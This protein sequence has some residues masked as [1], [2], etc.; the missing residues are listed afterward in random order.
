M[1]IIESYE[2]KNIDEI[3]DIN[4]EVYGD[5]SNLKSLDNRSI[6][7]SNMFL[8]LAEEHEKYRCFFEEGVDANGFR[9][10]HKEMKKNLGIGVVTVLQM[11]RKIKKYSNKK[12]KKLHFMKNYWKWN[13][14]SIYEYIKSGIF[15]NSPILMITWN[16]PEKDFRNNWIF[17]IGLKKYEDNTVSILVIDKGERKEY[18]LNDWIEGKSLYKGLMYYK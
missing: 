3:I 5:C 13:L 9:V 14:E 11:N 2:L 6:A 8:Y 10:F 15:S 12:G 16:F 18:S 7:V 17:I 1:K 4:K